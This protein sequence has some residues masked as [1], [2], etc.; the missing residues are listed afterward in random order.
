[1][2]ALHMAAFVLLVVGGLNWGLVGL[3]ALMNSAT[4]WN[5]VNMLVGTW[6]MVEN[7]VYVLVGVS[8]VIVAL[9]HKSDCKMCESRPMGM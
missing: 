4:S 8:A 1:M 9:G 2:K 5:L 3:A 7:L 6:P